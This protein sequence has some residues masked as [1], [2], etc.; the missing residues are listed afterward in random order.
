[1]SCLVDLC[2]FTPNTPAQEI[3]HHAT[4]RSALDCCIDCSRMWS[5]AQGMALMGTEPLP[6]KL[7]KGIGSYRLDTSTKIR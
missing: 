5:M 4:L 2:L 3:R 6:E 1:M 7:R